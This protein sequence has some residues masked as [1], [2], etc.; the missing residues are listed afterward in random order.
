MEICNL[1]LIFTDGDEMT[2]PY[3]IEMR[4]FADFK[5]ESALHKL[6][7]LPY[8][9]RNTG[10]RFMVPGEE[11]GFTEDITL[12]DTGMTEERGRAL[13][14]SGSINLEGKTSVGCAGAIITYLQRKKASE[15]L[16]G[17][18]TADEA[19]PILRLETFGL[20]SI[21]YVTGS[22]RTATSFADCIGR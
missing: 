12:G 3:K 4:P 8:L 10:V 19:Y 9:Q 11:E 13:H 14:V 2:L 7:G 17:D 5:Y 15:Y 6:S 22:H 16:H 20:K 21:M 18:P 1:F